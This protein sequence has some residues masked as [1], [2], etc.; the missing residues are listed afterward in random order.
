LRIIYLHLVSDKK[1]LHFPQ[2]TTISTSTFRNVLKWLKKKNKFITLSEAIEINNMG[3]DLRNTIVLTTDDGFEENYSIMAPILNELE[4]KSTMFLIEKCLDNKFLM[5]RHALFILEEKFKGSNYSK[6]IEPIFGDSKPFLNTDTL[7]SWS[8]RTWEMDKKDEYLA[9]LWNSLSEIK[10]SDYLEQ[11]KPYLST[12]QVEELIS[13]GHE[14]GGHTETHPICSKLPDD[15][16]YEEIILSTIKLAERFNMEKRVM[17]FPFERGD[18]NIT[19]KVINFTPSLDAMLG[20]WE[21]LDSY[22]N[23]PKYWERT[24]IEMPFLKAILNYY[25][26]PIKLSLFKK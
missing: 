3:G 18:L 22:K 23:D 13:N 7:L 11:E 17:S 2:L 20:T 8:Y 14:I 12:T 25:L 26:N 5:W 16:L 9:S 15:M 24:S 19:K 4:I 6:V 10:I 21:R 1:R